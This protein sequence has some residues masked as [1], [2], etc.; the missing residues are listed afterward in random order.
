MVMKQFKL[1]ELFLTI[2]IISTAVTGFVGVKK[3]SKFLNASEITSTASI[4]SSIPARNI[5]LSGRGRLSCF[6]IYEKNPR[7]MY[8]GSASGGLC[9]TEDGGHTFNIVFD[10]EGSSSIG[11]VTISQQN[12]NL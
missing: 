3:V 5:G 8:V 9:K 2:L 12:P 10:K 1:I 7:L 6:T 11:A 4:L